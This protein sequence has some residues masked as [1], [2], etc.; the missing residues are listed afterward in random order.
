MV[1]GKGRGDG[2]SGFRPGG[3]IEEKIRVGD[4]NAAFN[5][6]GIDW[7]S[8]GAST[9]ARILP[10]TIREHKKAMWDMIGRAHSAVIHPAQEMIS[11]GAVNLKQGVR[12][13]QG[14]YDHFSIGSQKDC[15]VVV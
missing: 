1:A 11:R 7:D 8:K 15:N 2:S 10:N 13:C 3:Y 6:R 12:T 4:A 9:P 5:Y 14:A